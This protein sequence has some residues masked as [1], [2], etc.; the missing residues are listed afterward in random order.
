MLKVLIDINVILDAC[1]RMTDEEAKSNPVGKILLAIDIGKIE[2]YF[3]A[4]SVPTLYYIVHSY[5]HNKKTALDIVKRTADF[6]KIIDLNETDCHL[7]IN[8]KPSDLE[9][10]ILYTSASRHDMDF[11]ITSNVKDFKNSPVPAI[12]PKNFLAQYLQKS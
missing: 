4:A 12:T 5:T 3:S 6:L 1:I 11:I 2:G 7:A 9:D 10:A 8:S